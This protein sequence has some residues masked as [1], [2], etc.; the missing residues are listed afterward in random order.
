MKYNRNFVLCL[1][2]KLCIQLKL[3]NNLLFLITHL[4]NNCVLC[5]AI[6]IN[7]IPQ[8]IFYLN[9]K[10]QKM[11]SLLKVQFNLK[12]VNKQRHFKRSLKIRNQEL[13]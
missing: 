1:Y 11:P 10:Q 8:Q 12:F 3:L 7:P 2:K 6:V 13:K 4:L 5:Q 9:I